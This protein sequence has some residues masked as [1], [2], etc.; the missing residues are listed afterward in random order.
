MKAKQKSYKITKDKFLDRQ[1]RDTLMEVCEHRAVMDTYKGRKVWVTRYMVVHL[2]LYSGLRVGEMSR[3]TI[4]DLHLFNVKEPYLFIK[5]GKGSR[6]RD[7]YIDRNLVTHLKEYLDIKKKG[8]LEP[9]EEDAP[10]FIGQRGSNI[11][12]QALEHAFKKSLVEAGLRKE[13]KKNGT[14]TFEKHGYSIHSCRHTYATFLLDSSKSL[15]YV[16]KQLGHASMNMTGL[17]ADV[18]PEM[19]GKLANTILDYEK[20]QDS[21]YRDKCLNDGKGEEK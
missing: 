16:Q 11:S 8:W 7:V 21:L 20:L 15:K 12:V 9:V 14:T 18:L 17:Y 1:Q 10:L 4:K 5:D 3:L 6:D 19:N 13:I 2:A